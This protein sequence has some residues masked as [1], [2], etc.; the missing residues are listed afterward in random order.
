MK[1]GFACFLL[2]A[3][4][5]S[6][7]ALAQEKNIVLKVDITGNDRIERGVIMNAIKTKEKETY[8]PE[9]IREDMKNIYKTG[10]FSDVQV[11]VKDTPEGKI[12][13]F[14]VVERPTVNDIAISGN[15]KVKTEDLK[16]KIKFKVGTVLNTEKLKETVD[17]IKKLYASKNF[18]AAKVTYDIDYEEGYRAKVTFVVD[19]AEKAYVR[20]ITFTG[21]NHFKA[22][23]LKDYMK[24]KEKGLLSWFTGS[25]ILDDEQLEEDRRNLGA[26]YA[27]NGYVRASVG[28][29]T[30]TLSKDGK[31]IDISIPITEGNIFKI[32]SVDFSGDL[33][34]PQQDLKKMVKSKVGDTFKSSVFQQDVTTLTDACQD[35]GYAFADVNPLTLVNDEAR[36]MAITFEIITGPQVYVNRINI[37]G[38]LK[39]RDKVIR[40]ELRFVEGD[41]FSA[42]KLKESKRRLR[43]TTY[44]KESDLKLVKTDVPDRVNLDTIVEEKPTGTISA[45]IGYSTYENLILTGSVAQDNLF[46]TGLAA[47]VTAAI[48]SISTLYDISITKPY[49]FD[50]DINAGIN[51]FNWTRSFDTYEYRSQ[52]GAVSVVRPITDYTRLGLKYGY[53]VT[54][55]FNIDP[56]AGAY[57]IS[58]RG[59]TR[60]SSVTTSLNYLTIDDIMNPRRGVLFNNSVEVAGGP[61]LGDVNF[62]KAISSYGRYFPFKWDTTFFVRGTGGYAWQYNGT[63]VPIYQ[64]FYVG[65]INSVRG[66]KYGMAGPTDY[67]NTP[68]GGRGELYFNFEWIFPIY[69]PAGLKGVVFF[70]LGHGFDH[71]DWLF[72]LRESAG[73]GI[74][75]LS[76]MGPIRLELGFNL[77]PKQG[78]KKEVFD[79]LMGRAF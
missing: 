61:F 27:D 60:T 4:L 67:Q 75:W 1:E 46:G 70:D 64:N 48:S 5:F 10:F 15:K 30:I 23:T 36:T 6:G 77:S 35:K 63:P 56:S 79:F 73:F 16:E 47:R 74:R 58:Q 49:I 34:I 32:G 55:V 62:I 68:I 53:V 45:G 78:E 69:A 43:N 19:E 26:F 59:V 39:T 12:V 21:N 50:K 57:I 52:G 40:R 25:G 17:E 8:N 24:T 44:F 72:N 7:P 41:L 76:P 65:G 42:A 66:F 20:K 33:V 51:L 28:N 31:R 22:G 2:L 38:N 11:D 14:V 71:S 13:T 3:F 37:T 18:Y 29:P 9:K 54:D